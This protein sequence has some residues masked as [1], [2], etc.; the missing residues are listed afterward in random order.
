MSR[1]LTT[2]NLQIARAVRPAALRLGDDEG[3]CVEGDT[4][5]VAALA[6]AVDGIKV[7][8]LNDDATN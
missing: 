7:I 6:D 1:L 3:E 2:G 4:L 8:F 5:R